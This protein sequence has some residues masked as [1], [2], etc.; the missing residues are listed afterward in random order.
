MSDI[1]GV[2]VNTGV[3]HVI[4]SA[5]LYESTYMLQIQQ[6]ELKEKMAAVV[7]QSLCQG[8]PV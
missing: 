2:A 8:V 4:S 1:M 7:S 5:L 6:E 3:S